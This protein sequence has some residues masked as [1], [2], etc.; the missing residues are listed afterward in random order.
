MD[1][2]IIVLEY[3]KVLL[4]APV[5]FGVIAGVCLYLF[6]EQFRS[7]LSRVAVIRWGGAELSAPQPPSDTAENEAPSAS[8]LPVSAQVNLPAATDDQ[9]PDA[10][11]EQLVHALQ[12]ERVRA[13]LWEYRYLNHFFVPNTQS[14]LDWL[15]GLTTPTTFT[16]YDALWQA[17]IPGASERQAIIRVLEDHNLVDTGGGLLVVTEKGREYIK[18]R[19]ARP[20]HPGFAVAS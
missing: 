20:P 12:A 2:P 10:V 13:H 19:G 11:K 15:S 5:I 17:F 3:V 6:K 4:S 18:W 9:L 7:L 16:T 8:D 14:V 1:T